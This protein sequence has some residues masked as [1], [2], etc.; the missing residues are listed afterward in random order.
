MRGI[1]LTPEYPVDQIATLGSLAENH[2]FDTI[3]VSSH[4]NNRDPFIS[5][6]HIC[7]QTNQINIGPGVVNPYETHPVTLISKIATLDEA[8]NGRSVFGIGAGDASTL[9]NLGII[10]DSPLRR[11]LETIHV[12]R[13]LFTGNRISHEGTFDAIDAGLNFEPI[14]ANIPIFVGAQGPHMIQMAAKYADGVLFNG[15]HPQDFAWAESKVKL[16]L[17]ERSSSLGEFSFTAYSSVSIDPDPTRA[18]EAAR[19]PVAFIAAGAND[20][21]LNK[22]SIDIS[23]AREIEQHIAA[24]N[25]TKAFS[26]VTNQ[27]IDTFCIAGDEQDVKERF[28]ELN[29]YVDSIVT[30]APLGPSPRDSIPLIASVFDKL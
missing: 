28:Q 2:N 21:V 25:F 10:R 30:A 22:H 5:L 17:N 1:E 7:Q 13:S 19:P 18:R 6:S 9:S 20:T 26:C 12:S 4:Y 23:I 8:S 16:G 24:G 29:T 15:A 27:M 3:F 11:V 14:N